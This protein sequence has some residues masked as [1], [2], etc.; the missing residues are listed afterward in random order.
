M[1][2]L[3]KRGFIKNDPHYSVRR[4]TFEGGLGNLIQKGPVVYKKQLFT[5]DNRGKWQTKDHNENKTFSGELK[6][7]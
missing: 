7:T 6:H 3:V 1:N 2:V 5:T 4:I